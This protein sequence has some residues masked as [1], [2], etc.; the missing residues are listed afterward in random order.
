[1]IEPPNVPN[2]KLRPPLLP[3]SYGAYESTSY[4]SPDH[5][6]I[7][8]PSRSAAMLCFCTMTRSVVRLPLVSSGP[9]TTS[10][11]GDAAN[12][13][14]SRPF[15]LPNPLKYPVGQLLLLL[16]VYLS[17]TTAGT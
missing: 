10:R 5:C 11:Y 14:S 13:Y 16:S 6:T 4:G 17:I 1:Y 8:L 2:V 12:S 7:R 3:M 15:C 9:L